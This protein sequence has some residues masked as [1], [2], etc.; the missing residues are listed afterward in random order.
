M[1]SM[2]WQLTDFLNQTRGDLFSKHVRFSHLSPFGC[3]SIVLPN[4]S[5]VSVVFLAS[6]EHKVILT[7]TVG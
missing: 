6:I 1:P 3:S 2:L 7:Q 5:A 4:I